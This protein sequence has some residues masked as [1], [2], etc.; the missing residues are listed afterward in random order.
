MFFRFG[1]NSFFTKNRLYMEETN[2]L[3][4]NRKKG[5]ETVL[6]GLESRK[7]STN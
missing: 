1:Q 6:K 2:F 5:Q 7:G 4:K 3:M